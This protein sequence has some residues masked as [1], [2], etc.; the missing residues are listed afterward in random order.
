MV[1]RKTLFRIRRAFRPLLTTRQLK[2]TRR[3]QRTP[4][5]SE[6][7]L[8]TS[9]AQ[10]SSRLWHL[11]KPRVNL[12]RLLTWLLTDYIRSPPQSTLLPITLHHCFCR[13]DYRR[14]SL[15]LLLLSSSSSNPLRTDSTLRRTSPPP[16]SNRSHASVR[17]L[18]LSSRVPG[19]PT[20]TL[21]IARPA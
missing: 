19:A 7:A 18:F 1:A 20:L 16:S 15:L 13:F 10:S 8:S 11:L 5:R 6:T 21:S 2:T 17:S 9:P 4:R 12:P 3:V 14:S